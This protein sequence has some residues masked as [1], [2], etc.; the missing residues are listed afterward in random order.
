MMGIEVEIEFVKDEDGKV[1]SFIFEQNNFKQE[2]KR[3]KK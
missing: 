2:G 1:S 3:V